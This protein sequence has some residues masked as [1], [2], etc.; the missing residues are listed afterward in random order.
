MAKLVTMLRLE[1]DLIDDAI[2]SLMR[3]REA[4]PRRHG[5]AFRA[6]ERRLEALPARELEAGLRSLPDSE[7]I[8]FI[9]TPPQEWLDILAE[10]KRLG[11]I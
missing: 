9:A 5:D 11:V 7:A 6:L 3:I 2:N 10:A 4:L 8:S 1:T